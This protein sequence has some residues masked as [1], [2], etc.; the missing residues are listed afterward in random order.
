VLVRTIYSLDATT[1][2][3][4]I[5]I[6]VEQ[7]SRDLGDWVRL[8]KN[9]F[10][11]GTL[12]KNHIRLLEELGLDLAARKRSALFHEKWNSSYNDLVSYR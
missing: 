4:I 12:S 5:F 8:N 10:R 11:L 9:S 3:L 6:L 7:A 2:V 1:I